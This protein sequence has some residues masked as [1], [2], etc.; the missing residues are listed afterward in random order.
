MIYA[1]FFCQLV[2]I[3]LLWL[4]CMLYW[5]W[6]S[7][8]PMVPSRPP[9]PTPPWRKRSREPKPFAGLTRKPPCDSC[10][11]YA[12]ARGWVTGVDTM[13]DEPPK[14]RAIEQVINI[15]DTPPL[16]VTLPV[17]VGRNKACGCM[18]INIKPR[19]T[20]PHIALRVSH[21]QIVCNLCKKGKG[22]WNSTDRR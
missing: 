9:H 12:P 10:D 16:F 5:V 20:H 22:N 19:K 11:R 6:L 2:L 21:C 17:A 3:A 14:L 1:L 4:C 7:D 15:C 8:R 18:W 13:C